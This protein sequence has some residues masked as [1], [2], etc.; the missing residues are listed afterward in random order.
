MDLKVYTDI[1]SFI[2]VILGA[3]AL[4]SLVTWILLRRGRK[5]E[6]PKAVDG[7]DILYMVFSRIDHRLK[8]AGEVIRGHLH[9]FNDELPQD[10]ER[11]RVAR[12]AIAEESSEITSLI[13]RL[14]LVVR[15][16]MSEQPLIIEPVNLPRL[17]EDIMVNLGPFADTKGITMGGVINKSSQAA[18]YI[19]GDA[20]ALREVFSNLMENSIRHNGSGTEITAEVMTQGN[21]MLVSIVDNGKGISQEILSHLFEKG[22]PRYHPRT[23]KGTGTG[24]YLCKLLVQLHG[25]QI[26]ADTIEGEKTAFRILLPI[27]RTPLQ[28]GRSST[29]S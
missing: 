12:K 15:L 7:K 18:D 17:L 20:S 4:G 2:G 25:G 5:S 3:V 24:L 6:G 21:N 1:W 8:T 27:R 13:N 28:S 11:W 22:G 9:G 29:V 19:S 26:T 16:G 10:A 23:T 14:D